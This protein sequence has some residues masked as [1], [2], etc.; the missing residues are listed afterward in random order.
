MWQIAPNILPL[1]IL[2][3][4]AFGAAARAEHLKKV[5]HF[6][7]QVAEDVY[8]SNKNT[9]NL[10]V[11]FFLGNG[12]TKQDGWGN[13]LKRFAAEGYL[14]VALN[15]NQGQMNDLDQT[16]DFTLNKYAAL[17]DKKRVAFTDGSHGEKYLDL[18]SDQDL[19][20]SVIFSLPEEDPA[21]LYHA[22]SRISN[23]LNDNLNLDPGST[24]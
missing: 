21:V 15:W 11:V 13:Y 3:L 10:P 9:N 14:T 19:Q 18:S 20:P 1:L 24:F 16:I 12:F 4:F 22:Y 5:N 7:P 17:I 6:Y 23:W 2:T 8:I